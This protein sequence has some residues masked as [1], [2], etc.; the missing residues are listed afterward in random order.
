MTDF[1]DVSDVSPRIAYIATN[2]QTVFTVPFAFLDETHL[3][4]YVNDVLKTLS[5]HYSTSGAEDED[6]GAVTLVTPSTAGD[7]V[8][9]ARVVPYE[10]ITHIPTSG[11]LDVPAINLQFALFVMMLQQAIADWPRSL[12]QPTSDADDFD[13]LPVAASRASKYL[14]F[15]AE[16]QPTVV[17]SV[18]TSVAASAF[19]LTLLDDATAAD[20]RST[21]G[22]TDQSS[23]VGAFLHQNF[24]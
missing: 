1:L 6:G 10:L 15:D 16:G 14:Y 18:S 9:I 19:M 20:A 11:D 7:S 13:E 21:L 5:T 17:S 4:V 22:I 23:A 3:E 8:V 12:R 24:R 2:G